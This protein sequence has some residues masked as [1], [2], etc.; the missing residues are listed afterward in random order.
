MDTHRYL[1]LISYA[2]VIAM[3]GCGAKDPTPPPGPG[4]VHVITTTT[5]TDLDL[6]GY[7]VQ[8]GGE[9]DP[10]LIMANDMVILSNLDP[11]SYMVFL[12]DLAGNC[13]VN[14]GTQQVSVSAEEVTEVPFEVSCA[15]LPPASVDVTGT[16][17]GSYVGKRTFDGSE[18]GG[19]FEF[20]LT[21]SGDDVTGKHWTIDPDTGERDPGPYDLSGRV[22][23][24]TVTMFFIGWVEPP[25]LGDYHVRVTMRGEV[26]GP[27][28]T[29]TESEQLDAWSATWTVTRQ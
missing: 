9:E 21:Q 20:E 6:D 5:G 8:V 26:S 13:A 24:S 27:V 15:E 18:G 12:T 22:S 23:D 16:W 28:M 7:L 4:I 1:T 25:F 29:G 3:G 17:A 19:D 11:G 2:S 14:V 10:H